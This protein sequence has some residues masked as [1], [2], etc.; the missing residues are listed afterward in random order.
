[1]VTFR[2]TDGHYVASLDGGD[3]RLVVPH[4]TES[5]SEPGNVEWSGDGSSLIYKR[6]DAR[7]RASF[8]TV[9]ASGGEPGLLL[10]L[11]DP[12]LASPRPEFAARP[13]HLFFTVANRESDVWTMALSSTRQ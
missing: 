10:T 8:W 2:G 1:M 13:T 12:R 11:D 5:D 4:D 9:P 3:A 6:M 7:G